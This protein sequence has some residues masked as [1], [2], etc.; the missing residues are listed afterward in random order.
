M[1]GFHSKEIKSN[2][3]KRFIECSYKPTQDLSILLLNHKIEV[4][5]KLDF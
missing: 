2:T 1:F 5:S 3:L 4:G